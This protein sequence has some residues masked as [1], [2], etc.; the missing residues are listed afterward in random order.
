MT[1]R[2]PPS[3]RRLLAAFPLLAAGC[4]ASVAAPGGAALRVLDYNIHAGKDAAG[5]HNLQRVAELVRETGADLVLL[6]EVDRGTERSGGEDQVATLSA[7]TGFHAAFGKTL[8][9]QGGE[10]GIAVLSRWPI[11]GDTLLS[12]PVVPP[13]ARSGGSHE[14]RGA[15]IARV[16]APS[17]ELHLVNTHLDASRDDHY[18]L[19][20][21][22]RVRAI[23][24]SLAAGGG[25]VLV[26]GDL[27][28]T[29]ESAVIASLTGAG[30]RD[31]WAGCGAG[32]GLTFPA[33]GPVKRIDYLL[34]RPGLGCDSATVLP[35]TASD[36]APILFLLR[37]RAAR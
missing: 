32:A 30:W 34:A 22:A 18:R 12:L 26:G 13:Q 31:L 6:Q 3:I 1:P 33:A 17:G 23:A 2:L 8:D 14:P 28:A 37:S 36:H 5:V 29:P 15:L 16:L 27:N 24:D 9:Y 21:V 20:E 19:Q 25:I 7:L 35:S 10:Y 11:D 4:V